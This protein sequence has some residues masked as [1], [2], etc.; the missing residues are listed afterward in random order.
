[1]RFFQKIHRRLRDGTLKDIW[2]ESL[3]IYRY[4]RQYHRAIWVYVLLGFAST[5]LSLGTSVATKFL[6]DIIESHG[7]AGAAGG[8]LGTA[9]A[10]CVFFG[11]SNILMS[12]LSSRYSAKINL[13]ISNEIRADVYQKFMQTDLESVQAFH[14]GDLLNRINTDVTTVA[15]SVLGWIPTLMIKLTQFIAALAIILYYDPTMALIAL[16]TAPVTLIASRFLVGRM[17]SYSQ[18][19][20]EVNSEVISVHEE[21]LQNIQPIKALNL[22]DAFYRKILQ[23]QQKYY[24]TAMDYNR[25]SVL[26]SMTMSLVGLVVSYA[27]LGWAVYRLWN[28]AITFGT[29]VLFIQLAAYLSSSFSALVN[30]VPSAISATVSAKRL[31]S[32]LELPR[33]ETPYR[34]EV[35]QLVRENAPI[36]IRLQGLTFGYRGGEAVLQDTDLQINHGEM[37]AVIGPSGSGKTTLFRL[38]LGLLNPQAGQAEVHSGSH[39]VPL[40]PSTRPLFSYVPQ[41]SVIFSGTIADTLRLVKPDATD[42]EIWQALEAA[43]ADAFVK[44]LPQG[45]NSKIGERGSTLSGGQNQRLAIARALLSNAPI[46]LLDEVTAALDLETEQ[47]VLANI[48]NA[49]RGRTCIVATHRHSVLPLCHRVYRIDGRR[50]IPVDGAQLLHH[51]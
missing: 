25:F 39:T 18:K 34:A 14:S 28:R 38:L 21:S 48:A 49:Y 10:L 44:K 32:V 6:I 51:T 31:I 4:V 37:I 9:A 36:S 22:N 42:A 5:A 16:I 19:M 2:R 35:E 1:M 46:L 45:L 40:S 17:R 43:C 27:C 26:T 50:L 7:Q 13:R 41:D 33:E 30:L 47:Q 24:N 12:S 29:M 15:E 23:V 8:R 20:R 3:W 11:V